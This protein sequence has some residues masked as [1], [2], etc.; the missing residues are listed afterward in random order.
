MDVALALLAAGAFAAGTVL[1]QKGALET[2]AEADDP[3]FLVQLLRQRVWIVGALLQVTGWVLQAAALDHGPLVVVQSLT[4]LSL[5]VALPLGVRM[6]GQNLDRRQ[7]GAALAVTMGI[8]LL[9]SVGAPTGGNTQP[10]A[11]DWWAAGVIFLLLI[12]IVTMVGRRRGGATRALLFGSG[13]GLAFG[14]QAA[15]T[16]VF[17]GALGNG[18]AALLGNWS[19]YALIVS[20]LVGF[21]L[22]QS[23]LKTGIL[24]PSIASS[25]SITLFASVGLG[26]SV[27][28]ESLSRG[29]GH[30]IPAV[31]G[32]VIAA[33]GIVGLAGGSG[34][35][36]RTAPALAG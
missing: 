11:A 6:T 24:A 19:I 26:I 28:G 13:A 1:Q 8:V 10:S 18:V 21:A 3:R 33:A 16:K 7:V 23:A 14:F 31:V 5:V 32:L 15:V 4:A 36:V 30:L 34:S 25:N 35:E 22:L 2:P 12:G 27:F 20:A 9:L 17:V 29:G